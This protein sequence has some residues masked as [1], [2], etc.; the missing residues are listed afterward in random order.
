MHNIMQAI[1]TCGFPIVMALV[2]AY[3]IVSRMDKLTEV[4]SQN[5]TAL[6]KVCS[7]LDK[8]NEVGYPTRKEKL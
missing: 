6:E 5:T 2:E 4:V 7:V 8:D 3:Y 1:S